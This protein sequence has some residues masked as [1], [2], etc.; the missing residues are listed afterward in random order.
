MAV[1]RIGRFLSERMAVRTLSGS[2]PASRFSTRAEP[3]PR[4]DGGLQ[5]GAPGRREP[6][7]LP[8]S[9]ARGGLD[10]ALLGQGLEV[11]DQGGALEPEPLGERR[12]GQSGP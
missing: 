1:G 5:Y 8:A 7:A 3:P 12:L 11:A 4:G 2:A 9:V 6:V 10:P